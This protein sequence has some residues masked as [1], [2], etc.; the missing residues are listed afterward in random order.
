MI[1]ADENEQQERR[2]KGERDLSEHD[3]MVARDAAHASRDTLHDVNAGQEAGA[4]TT[5]QA[6]DRAA[7]TPSLLDRDGPRTPKEQD[8]MLDA[9]H[10]DVFPTDKAWEAY[11]HENSPQVPPHGEE[12]RRQWE[13]VRQMSESE[14]PDGKESK[15]T[16]TPEQQA[17]IDKALSRADLNDQ[18]GGASDVSARPVPDEPTPMEK[19]RDIGQDLQ[20]Q[21]VTMEK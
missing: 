18:I 21:G 14:T 11:Q 2:R 10:R 9:L 8:Q 13:D 4:Y 5:E 6:R 3:R 16:M 19:A 7:H 15:S 1:V 12:A 20:K 17:S